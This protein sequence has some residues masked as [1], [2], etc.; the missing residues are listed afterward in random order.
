MSAEWI[1]GTKVSIGHDEPG[2][3]TGLQLVEV[4]V[5]RDDGWVSTAEVHAYVRQDGKVT[6]VLKTHTGGEHF[7]SRACVSAWRKE[8]KR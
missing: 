4:N 2:M 7:A 3:S 8:K 1:E 5:L 6:F